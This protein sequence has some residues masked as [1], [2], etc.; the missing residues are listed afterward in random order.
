MEMG[1]IT[2]KITTFVLVAMLVP[3]PGFAW[4]PPSSRRASVGE[5]L[6][7]R[8]FA[9]ALNSTEQLMTGPGKP[10][11]YLVFSVNMAVPPARPML[12]AGFKSWVDKFLEELKKQPAATGPAV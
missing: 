12:N 4:E 8:V 1:R 3:A 2:R 9:Y 6:A 11:T 5:P 10:Q 7:D